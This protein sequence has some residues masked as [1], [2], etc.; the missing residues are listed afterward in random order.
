MPSNSHLRGQSFEGIR[1][2]H[3]PYNLLLIDIAVFL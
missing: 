2:A 1:L 3:I